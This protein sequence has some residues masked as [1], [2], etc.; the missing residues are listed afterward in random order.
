MVFKRLIPKALRKIL[1][2]SAITKSVIDKKSAICSG[3]QVNY[4]VIDRYSYIGYNCFLLNSK[5]GP[6]VSIADNC[7]IGGDSHPIQRVSSSPVFHSG[8][9]VLHKNFAVFEK[10]EAKEVNIGPDVWIGANAIIMSGVSIGVGAV[11][12]AGSVVTHDVGAYEIWCGNPARKLRDRFPLDVKEGLLSSNW[13]T[14]S[15]EKISDYSC[16]FED[17]SLFL[18]KVKK[19]RCHL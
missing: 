14:W 17:V 7:R 1:Q 19:E 11:I 13:W 15:E 8:K 4:S 12:G 18:E 9:N 5:I 16:Y 3:S 6:F 2:P 10:I